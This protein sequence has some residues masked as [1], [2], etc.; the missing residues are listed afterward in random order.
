MG[1]FPEGGNGEEYYHHILRDVVDLS[2]QEGEISIDY[3]PAYDGDEFNSLP[4]FIYS[5]ITF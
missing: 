1:Y 3:N 5:S 4:F 2:S